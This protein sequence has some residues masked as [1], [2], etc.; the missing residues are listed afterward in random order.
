MLDLIE[1]SAR[2][3]HFTACDFCFH[4]VAH[5][6]REYPKLLVWFCFVY[7]TYDYFIKNVVS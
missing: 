4:L 3:Y 2:V 5:Q 6:I 7:A 1:D